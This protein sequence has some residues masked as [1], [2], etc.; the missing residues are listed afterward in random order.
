MSKL[1]RDE[2]IEWLKQDLWEDYRNGYQQFC[3]A[4]SKVVEWLDEHPKSPWVSVSDGMPDEGVEVLIKT[5]SGHRFMA[6]RLQD[7]WVGG[8]VRE[9]MLEQSDIVQWMTIPD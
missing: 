1:T 8:H 6:Y 5:K 7:E 9:Y 2:Q 4:I 3:N